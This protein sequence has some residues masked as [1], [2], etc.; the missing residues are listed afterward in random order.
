MCAVVS[1]SAR[2]P[3]L[4]ATILLFYIVAGYIVA[5]AII[6]LLYIATLSCYYIATTVILLYPT[7][8]RNPDNPTF[9]E[10]N[11]IQ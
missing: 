7:L 3:L 8:M 9:I 4:F 11:C 5:T 1:I 6:L 10:H 2:N